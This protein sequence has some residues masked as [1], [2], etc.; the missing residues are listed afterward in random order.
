MIRTFGKHE[1]RVHA[2]AFVHDSAEVIG[3][4]SLGRRSSVWPLCV[5]RGD[6]E[7]IVIGQDSNIQDLT[8]IHT[9]TGHP[10]VLGKRV[11]VGHRVVLHGCRIG[12]GALIGMGAVV[13]EARL[14]KECLV[15]AGAVVPPGA[16]IPARH[17]AVG[18][19]A[20]VVRP[21]TARELREVRAGMSEY[22]HLSRV[23]ADD[24]RPVFPR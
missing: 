19:P 17:L 23:H 4:V 8:C 18:V 6:E 12:D 11:T 15:G 20:K 22:L 9:R 1:P 2:T 16:V 5:L 3:R 21:L 14:G 13:M 7:P 24:S 10:A